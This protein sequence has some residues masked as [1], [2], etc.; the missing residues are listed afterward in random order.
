MSIFSGELFMRHFVVVFIAH[1]LI[2]CQ[3]LAGQT[4]LDKAFGE[5]TGNKESILLSDSVNNKSFVTSNGEKV[6]R[7][8]VVLDTSLKAVWNAFTNEAEITTWEVT[9]AK[10]DLRIG[11]SM[12]THYKKNASIGDPGTITLG[13]INYLPMELLTYKITLTDAFPEKCRNEDDNLQEIIQFIALEKNKTRITSSMI[14]WGTGKEWDDVYEKFQM[15]NRWTYQQ[16]VK[17]FRPGPINR[18]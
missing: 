11:G 7:F 14:G 2:F 8:E 1:V 17:H 9:Q 10:L 4:K 5:V 6:L 12:Q 18:K 16:L 13:I 15:G 3:Q